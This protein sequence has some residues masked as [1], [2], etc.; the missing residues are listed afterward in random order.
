VKHNQAI[1]VSIEERQLH[2][3]FFKTV[4]DSQEPWWDNPA[5]NPALG[6]SFHELGPQGPRRGAL[7]KPEEHRRRRDKWVA[8]EEDN[9]TE[10][11]LRDT[12]RKQRELEDSVHAAAVHE[13]RKA[14]V[15]DYGAMKRAKIDEIQYGKVMFL[16]DEA[17]RKEQLLKQKHDRSVAHRL[18]IENRRQAKL[19]EQSKRRDEQA[20]AVQRSLEQHGMEEELQRE[21]LL[22]HQALVDKRSQ[23]FQ[24]VRKSEVKAFQNSRRQK[25]GEV[26]AR[27]SKVMEEQAKWKTEK[28]RILADQ[29]ERVEIHREYKKLQVDLQKERS[30]LRHAD[31]QWKKKHII[32]QVEKSLHEVDEGYNT[33]A[34]RLQQIECS[35]SKLQCD[36]RE[37]ARQRLIAKDEAA[38]ELRLRHV[39]GDWNKTREQLLFPSRSM[40]VPIPQCAER[41]SGMR[42]AATTSQLPSVSMSHSHQVTDMGFMPLSQTQHMG[43][44]SFLPPRSAGGSVNSQRSQT[45]DEFAATM[46]SMASVDDAFARTPPRMSPSRSATPLRD[47]TPSL[48]SLPEETQLMSAINGSA[49]V[50]KK[51]HSK[52]KTADK[53]T[54]EQK[55]KEGAQITLT[56]AGQTD[57]CQTFSFDETDSTAELHLLDEEPATEGNVVVENSM[58]SVHTEPAAETSVANEG[59]TEKATVADGIEASARQ[60]DESQPNNAMADKNEEVPEPVAHEATASTEENTKQGDISEG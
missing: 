57:L 13:Q 1:A 12:F 32:Q 7:T 36:V 4:V 25:E 54:S 26:Q 52:Q 15:D 6:K 5:K 33:K 46:L 16:H 21:E 22:R 53:K 44:T 30:R 9:A 28:I 37:S 49:P 39:T 45:P 47:G 38:E 34:V 56:V 18:E 55:H 48:A 51:K 8:Q 50:R 11:K 3:S 10:I 19:R 60:V 2:D 43:S 59:V 58:E 35:M 23:V 24:K 31:R 20:L 40:S 17:E 27:L 14:V 42:F 29:A 41:S